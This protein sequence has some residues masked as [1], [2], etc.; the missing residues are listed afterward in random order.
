MFNAVLYYKVNASK[1][2][3]LGLGVSNQV[4]SQLQKQFSFPWA[5]GSIQYLDVSLTN[6]LSQLYSANFLPLLNSFSQ[7]MNRFKKFYLSW[8]GRLAAYKMLLLPKLLYYFR[9]LPIILPSI[10]SVKMQCLISQFIWEGEKA[11]CSLSVLMKHRR[12]GAWEFQC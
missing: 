9:A 8:S 1:S 7:E 5:T 6:P 10:F 12:V 3:I 4:M 2:S 11:R